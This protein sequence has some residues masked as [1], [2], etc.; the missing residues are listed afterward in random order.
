M[1]RTIIAYEHK[2]QI[3]G[4]F[5]VIDLFGEETICLI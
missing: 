3:I 5:W 4:I 2:L 1:R